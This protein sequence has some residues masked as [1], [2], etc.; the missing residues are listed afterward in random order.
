MYIY[1]A[2]SSTDKMYDMITWKNRILHSSILVVLQ[3]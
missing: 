2:A 1:V 3:Y